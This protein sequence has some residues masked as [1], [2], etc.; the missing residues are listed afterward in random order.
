MSDTEKLF[1]AD[2]LSDVQR[3]GDYLEGTCR[4]IVEACEALGLDEGEDWDDKLLDV[5]V[6]RCFG[7]D[8]WFEV[9][10]LEF[11]ESR[12]GGMCEQCLKDEGLGDE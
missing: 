1:S 7:C 11:V 8:H 10:M 6:E 4:T 2:G 3:L 5:N 9:C 12:N